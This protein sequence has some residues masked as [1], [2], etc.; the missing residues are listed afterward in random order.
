APE[1]AALAE[2]I[3]EIGLRGLRPVSSVLIPS[4][5][6]QAWETMHEQ[7]GPAKPAQR[8]TAARRGRAAK[9]PLVSVCLVHYERPRQL[10]RAVEHLLQQ[11]YQSTEII[12]VDDGSQSVSA[13][14][15]LDDLEARHGGAEFRVIRAP[16]RYLGAARNLAASVARGDFLMFH[17]DDNIAE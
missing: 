8:R 3:D 4:R 9:A 15:A 10:A 5:I 2:R 17:D 11:T 1:P 13:M 16:N 6:M 14:K 12:I 7:I